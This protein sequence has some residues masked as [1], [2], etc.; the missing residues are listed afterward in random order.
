MTT[1][2]GKYLST[3]DQPVTK[4]DIATSTI[5]HYIKKQT[6]KFEMDEELWNDLHEN[7]SCENTLDNNTSLDV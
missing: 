3:N 6:S 2:D 5:P 4:L 7:Y 1:L